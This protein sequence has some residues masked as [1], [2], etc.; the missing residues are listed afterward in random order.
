MFN[1]NIKS[2]FLNN[3]L[4]LFSGTFIGQLIPFIALPILQRYFYS[5]ADF[6]FLALFI[7]LF[8]L[9]SKASTLKLEYGIPL[10]KTDKGAINLLNG[11][12]FIVL[13]ISVIL[14]V[15]VFFFEGLIS[16]HYQLNEYAIYLYLLPLYVFIT[17]LNDIGVYWF[18]RTKKFLIMSSAKVVQ[19]GSA[20][21]S[22]ISLGWLDFSFLGLLLGRIIGFFISL[23]FFITKFVKHDI[24]KVKLINKKETIKAIRNNKSFIF[25]STPSVFIGSLINLVYLSLFQYYFSEDLVGKIGVSMTYLAAGFGVI[26]VSFSQVYYA[27]I[28]EIS[29]KNELLK[30]YKRFLSRLLLFTMLPI[31]IVYLIPSSMV[32]YLLGDAWSELIEIARIMVLWLS[33]W[34]VS[35]S[36]SFIFIRLGRQKEM[37]F[38]DVF[39]LILIIIGFFIG[40]SLKNDFFYALWGFTISQIV[41]YLF[42]IFS[43]IYFIKKI[44]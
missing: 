6:G 13:I 34:F 21:S 16:E 32:V 29:D 5:P 39:H 24:A 30:T 44:K 12:V 14:G 36:L 26:S 11:A 20:E 2:D 33:I 38:F 35:S 27:K 9:F 8:E 42:A 28:S 25:F 23:I 41:Y 19:A 3:L 7:S 4:V 10:Q 15:A 17:S 37:V 18:N 43:A 40:I 1:K 22:K 31:G